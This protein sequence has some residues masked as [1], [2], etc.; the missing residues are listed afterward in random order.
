MSLGLPMNTISVPSLLTF[1]HWPTSRSSN[2]HVFGSVSGFS[3]RTHEICAIGIIRMTMRNNVALHITFSR[4]TL[5]ANDCIHIPGWLIPAALSCLVMTISS[6]SGM[7][8]NFER[9]SLISYRGIF[10]IAFTMFFKPGSDTCLPTHSLSGAGIRCLVANFNSC[11]KARLRM[12]LDSRIFTCR[13]SLPVP[14]S[15]PCGS[16]NSAP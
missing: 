5:P 7:R 3:E 13:R 4:L 14:R 8:R 16:G 10:F 11:R 6:F 1:F 9:L 2:E 12:A 15:S